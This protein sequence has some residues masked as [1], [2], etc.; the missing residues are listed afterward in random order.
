M[1]LSAKLFC[2]VCGQQTNHSFDK[3]LNQD[4]LD[5]IK[6][7]VKD[8]EFKESVRKELAL[9][10][11]EHKIQLLERQSILKKQYDESLLVKSQENQELRDE[12]TFL[13][14]YQMS[15][16]S[17]DLGEDLENRIYSDY[18]TYLAALLPNAS[19]GK[20]NDS[21]TGTKG[22]HIFR[23]LEFSQEVVSIMFDM[24]S[25]FLIKKT[26][27]N[28]NHKHFEKLNKDRKKAGCE[29]AVLISTLERQN[30][31]F[32]SGMTFI[33][34][35]DYEKMIVV[36][37]ENFI[38]TIITLRK[39]GQEKLRLKRDL[40]DALS[41]NT[42]VNSLI[43]KLRTIQSGSVEYLVKTHAAVKKVIELADKN[44]AGAN[45]ILK[46]SREQKTICI[47]NVIETID[48]WDSFVKDLS[49][50]NTSESSSVD[51]SVIQGAA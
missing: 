13:K 44:I 25:E 50:I 34:E 11:S 3:S 39:L 42:D 12:I 19:F 27:Q 28:K 51:L 35:G 47:N 23:E 31:Q 30:K 43:K 40:V 46:N 17:K 9:V 22:D 2:K 49:I 16:N 1:T 26:D 38:S 37:P 32:S 41:K 45:R 33:H 36:R 29:W 8:E 24:K 48:S 18:Q 4:L 20:D 7:E 6:K 5:Q 14:S 10:N 15:L 21:S